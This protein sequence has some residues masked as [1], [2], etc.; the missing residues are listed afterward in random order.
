MNTLFIKQNWQQIH[1]FEKRKIKNVE[2]AI[3]AFDKNEDGKLTNEDFPGYVTGENKVTNT[4]G[5][6]VLRGNISEKEKREDIQKKIDIIKTLSQ[7]ERNELKKR[8]DLGI[9]FQHAEKFKESLSASHLLSLGEI[10]RYMTKDLEIKTNVLENMYV[11]DRQPSEKEQPITSGK[12]DFKENQKAE[13]K[14]G[15]GDFLTAS[16][17]MVKKTDGTVQFGSLQERHRGGYWEINETGEKKEGD[18]YLEVYQGYEFTAFYNYTDFKSA[19]LQ[20][21]SE[22]EEK[23]INQYNSYQKPAI[24][25]L[26]KTHRKW[27]EEVSEEENWSQE[28]QKKLEKLGVNLDKEAETQQKMENDYRKNKKLFENINYRKNM[29][30]PLKKV[31]TEM[32]KYKEEYFEPVAKK[33]GVPWE[34]VAAIHYRECGNNFSKFN[35]YLHNG[36]KLGTPTT[37]VPKGKNFPNNKNGWISAAEDALINT[38]R[39]QEI[40][41]EFQYDNTDHLIKSAAI[42]ELFNGPGY[43][44]K[45]ATSPY[46]FSGTNRYSSGKYV[47]DGVFDPS[48]IDKQSGIIA[49]MT[50]LDMAERNISFDTLS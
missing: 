33:A 43:R 27:Q 24:E 41:T 39:V 47:K 32:Q 15:L 2:T 16:Y 1:F 21:N 23:N 49:I 19:Y 28:A 29:M 13:D 30:R 22:K 37:I 40:G 10:S 17:V 36:Q 25:S 26:E 9:F 35:T 6:P 5:N 18:D 12:M 48:E 34:L 38:V 50:A 42:A 20:H 44:K 14:I 45:G 3:K 46:V 31:A 4:D 11:R 7:A 8:I